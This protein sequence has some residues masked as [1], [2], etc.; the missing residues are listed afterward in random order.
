MNLMVYIHEFL[1]I[2]LFYTCFCRSVKMNSNTIREI[3]LAFYGLSLA[4]VVS[5]FAPMRG[6]RPDWIHIIMLLAINIVQYTTSKF[7]HHSL[8]SSFEKSIHRK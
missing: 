8:P 7:W 6:W 4:A 3:R 2:F 5:I 1:A